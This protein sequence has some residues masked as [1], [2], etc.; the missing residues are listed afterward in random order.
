MNSHY[1]VLRQQGTG[2]SAIKLRMET[3]MKKAVVT[4]L[5]AMIL[6]LSRQAAGQAA[7]GNLDPQLLIAAGNGD[8]ATVQQLLDKGANIEAK[9]NNGYTALMWA[10]EH[11]YVEAVKL[12]LDKGANIEAKDQY[13]NTALVEAVE[14][15]KEEV[16]KLL[17]SKGADVSSLKY[18]LIGRAGGC[19]SLVA[20]R[21]LVKV[22]LMAGANLNTKASDGQTAL[23]NSLT[24]AD[25][26]MDAVRFLIDSGADVNAFNRMGGTA[27]MY[28]AARG[29]ADLVQALIAKGAN[30]NAQDDS[31]QSALRAACGTTPNANVVR[32]LIQ[33]G[34][35]VNLTDKGGQTAM[36]NA[37]FLKNVGAADFGFGPAQMKEMT[38]IVNLLHKAGAKCP[39]FCR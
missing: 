6:F 21:P 37:V 34:A 10:A 24:N 30:L 8:V 28:A 35:N 1:S 36:D 13:G 22:L 38:D 14:E 39:T 31:G 29:N 5:F 18:A 9:E 11:G 15:N 33:K 19:N 16:V 17:L 2:H 7:A 27:L 20:I 4:I 23:M 25:C 3:K 26:N 12:L 32:I